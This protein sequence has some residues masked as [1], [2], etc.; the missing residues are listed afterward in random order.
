MKSLRIAAC[1]TLVT[2]SAF[3]AGCS[4]TPPSEPIS[5]E[6]AKSCSAKNITEDAMVKIVNATA[7]T[8]QIHISEV[9]C[10]DWSG[11]ENPSAFDKLI[12]PPGTSYSARLAA[13]ETPQSSGSIRPWTMKVGLQVDQS[14]WKIGTAMTP[15]PTFVAA[16]MRCNTHNG[17][18]ACVGITMCDAGNHES[19]SG[20]IAMPNKNPGTSTPNSYKVLIEC[21]YDSSRFLSTA[22]LVI[23]QN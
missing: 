7:D 15:R 1:V 21:G 10:Y 18:T 23:T 4:S 16:P 2:A 20:T 3:L 9:N 22:D 12:L 14:S 19:G 17:S 8:I 13:R 11:A 5:R 6:A